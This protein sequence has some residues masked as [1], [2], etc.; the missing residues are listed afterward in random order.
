[1]VAPSSAHPCLAADPQVT[2][3]PTATAEGID[4]AAIPPDTHL[5][6]QRFHAA[7]GSLSKGL[8]L[9]SSLEFRSPASSS[10]MVVAIVSAEA[11]GAVMP[12]EYMCAVRDS[13][14]SPRTPRVYCQEHRRRTDLHG[15]TL[16]SKIPRMDQHGTKACYRDGGCRCAPAKG[17]SSRCGWFASEPTVPRPD[18][19]M[20]RVCCFAAIA[21]PTSDPATFSPHSRD[22]RHPGAWPDGPKAILSAS[23]ADAACP[24]E[25]L[26]SRNRRP[27]EPSPPS[28][29]S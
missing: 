16:G 20:P 25:T 11:S 2:L 26:V 17:L 22:D 12:W 23:A 14:I 1:M 21:V 19:T 24:V 5:A 18:G 9:S 29:G 28:V 10:Q 6:G 7:V 15:E 4:H 27:P 8:S 3:G 13:R